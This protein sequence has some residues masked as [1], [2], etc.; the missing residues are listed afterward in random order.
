MAASKAYRCSSTQIFHSAYD[1]RSENEAKMPENETTHA[2]SDTSTPSLKAVANLPG[3]LK[4]GVI[5]AVSA[6]AGGLAASW[7][8]KKTLNSFR[9]AESADG[10][11]EFRIPDSETEYDI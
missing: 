7:Y 3:W 2:K 5:A 8:Y 10:N 6:L 11:P 4:V 9:E 1:M